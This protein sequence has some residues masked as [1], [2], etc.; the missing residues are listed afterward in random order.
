MSCVFQAIARGGR[1]T[2]EN[3]TVQVRSMIFHGICCQKYGYGILQS[4]MRRAVTEELVVLHHSESQM[5]LLIDMLRGV[6]KET[7]VSGILID[8]HGV[9]EDLMIA[10]R[11][12]ERG[13]GRILKDLLDTKPLMVDD[14]VRVQLKGSLITA[15]DIS[16]IFTQTRICRHVLVNSTQALSREVGIVA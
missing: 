16:I 4:T 11:D 15:I 8:S 12:E 1:S 3:G 14:Q 7:K 6:L 13:G 2:S 10:L 5:L 9:E